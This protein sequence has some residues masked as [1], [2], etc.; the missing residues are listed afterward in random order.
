MVKLNPELVATVAA[1]MKGARL[2]KFEASV[3]ILDASLAQG[4]WT[5][6]GSVKAASG[7]YQGL[8]NKATGHPDHR[9]SMCLRFGSMRYGVIEPEVLATL[10]PLERAWMELCEYVGE[11]HR[12]LDAARPLPIKTAIGLSPKV[13][14]TF[15]ECNLD[16]VLDTI[17][18]PPIAFY[19]R[20]SFT[21]SAGGPNGPVRTLKFDRDGE[22]VMER[23]Y[24]VNWPDDIR[25]G[26]SRFAGSGGCEACGKT[27]P[28][29][30]FVPLMAKCRKQGLVSLW[31]GCDCAR[32]I[33]G[34][35]DIGITKVEAE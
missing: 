13:T 27:I 24:Y 21:W 28:S 9:I 30:K 5:P 17:D 14:K 31:V 29:G 32:N 11:A 33:F 34:I 18:M 6:R 8:R 16:L 10:G 22:P 26:L 2:A 3:A 20:Q 35:K 7:F 25:H 19:L 15:Q 12:E 23:V 1:S 4:A